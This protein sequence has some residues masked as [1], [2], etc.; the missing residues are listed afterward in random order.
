MFTCFAIE[1]LIKSLRRL[2]MAENKHYIKGQAGFWSDVFKIINV[3]ALCFGGML[4]HVG[5]RTS[6]S[7]VLQEIFTFVSNY[8]NHNKT[9]VELISFCL[10]Y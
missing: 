4:L 6:M 1:A 5:T 8:C 3:C 2:D 9:K 7:S 10:D